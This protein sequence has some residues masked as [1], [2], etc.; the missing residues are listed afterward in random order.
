MSF[1][2]R[3]RPA[4]SAIIAS[5]SLAASAL[6]G[7]TP[8]GSA[9][10]YQGQLKQGGSPYSGV[11][12]F[13][14]RLYDAATAG[15]QIGSTIALMRGNAP[16]VSNGVFKATLDFGLDGNGFPAFNGDARWL[17]VDV[18]TGLGSFITLSPRQA[19][20]ATPYALA[21]RGIAADSNGFVGI[22][23][24]LP[25]AP[26]HVLRGSA[27]AVAAFSL[28]SLALE[29]STHNYLQMLAP[30]GFENGILFGYPTTGAAEGGIIY[31]GAATNNGLEFRTN[32]NLTRMSINAIGQVM[33]HNSNLFGGQLMVEANGYGIWA[34]TSGEG[35]AIIGQANSTT[36]M[37]TGVWGISKSPAGSGVEGRNYATTGGAI[38]VRA[39]CDSS[40]GYDFFAAGAGVDYGTTSSIR[41]KRNI[42]PIADPL[43]R[44]EQIRGVWYDWDA[45]HGGRHDVGMI[46]EEVGKVMPE[47]VAW[48]A[49]GIDANGMDYGKLT[50]LLVEAVKALRAEKDEQFAALEQEKQQLRDRLAAL[51]AAVA[52]LTPVRDRP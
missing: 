48:E 32:G 52:R 18:R 15:N 50:P 19:I 6:A 14:F 20:T 39:K 10:T 21:T 51:E 11:A 2:N 31:N 17:E 34:N 46:A 4:L 43:D 1:V 16:T 23:T 8:L 49:N 33:I 35:Q 9:F 5:I 41:W 42:M 30:T 36:G 12:E 27:G 37:T 38:G 13:Q 44:V 22:G 47:I 3:I 26:L 25:E 45:A 40:A 7:G 28:S 29:G 24:G